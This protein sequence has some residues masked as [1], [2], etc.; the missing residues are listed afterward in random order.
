MAAGQARFVRGAGRRSGGAGAAA[1]GA[2]GGRGAGALDRVVSAAGQLRDRCL[3]RGAG[4]APA[5]APRRMGPSGLRLPLRRRRLFCVLG[6]G[7]RGGGKYPVRPA[8]GPAHGRVAGDPVRAGA[9]FLRREHG[10]AAQPGQAGRMLRAA[11]AQADAGT[12][13]AGGPDAAAR[14]L[15]FPVWPRFSSRRT[16]VCAAPRG[17]TAGCK[18]WMPGKDA[19]SEL[20]NK[21]Q[22]DC[23]AVC[24][25]SVYNWDR[26]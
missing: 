17:R 23:V 2:G 26:K 19:F 18:I 12:A 22:A 24:L 6:A 1:A 14:A 16:S 25:F 9:F 13:G 15:G 7:L 4:Q 10:A 21:K 11:A 20:S 3:Q 8:V 5:R